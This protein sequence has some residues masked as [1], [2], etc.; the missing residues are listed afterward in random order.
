MR[1]AL[2]WLAVV[3][4]LL[5]AHSA[6]ST[7]PLLPF[8]PY[9]NDPRL[10]KMRSFLKQMDSPAYFLAGEF[11]L[12]ADRNGLDWRLLPSISIV[13]SGGGKN[14]T[15]NNILGWDSCRRKFP[16]VVEGVHS[17]AHSL[18]TS[19][20]YKNKSLDKMLAT[21]NPHRGYAGKVKLLMEHMGPRR[22]ATPAF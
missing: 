13:E 8:E 9:G 22:G 11:L 12:A 18:A 5:L 20:L 7:S 15:N 19:K 14:Y 6:T 1:G 2:T 3:A 21:Y 4:G 16:S 10:L 17:V